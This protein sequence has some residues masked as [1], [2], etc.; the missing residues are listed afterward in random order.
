MDDAIL[1]IK[2]SPYGR[3]GVNNVWCAHSVLQ[4]HPKPYVHS[5][6]ISKAV[7]FSL[8]LATPRRLHLNLNNYGATYYV[9]LLVYL[10]TYLLTHSLT[11]L[12][13]YLLTSKD[14]I[15]YHP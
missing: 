7:C 8:L 6:T 1:E 12:H 4:H 14:I 11:Y 9:Y 5:E 10:L 2:T 13:T 3:N 15:Q